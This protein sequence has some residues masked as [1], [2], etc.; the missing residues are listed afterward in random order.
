MKLSQLV[1]IGCLGFLACDS[2]GGDA[3]TEIAVAS[4]TLEV[5]AAEDGEPLPDAAV[6][7]TLDGGEMREPDSQDD[8]G[9]FV[10]DYEETGAFLVTVSAPGFEMLTR[11]YNVV[12]EEGGCHPEGVSDTVELG[13][14]E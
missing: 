14:A 8:G 2:D 9:V 7:F 13:K 3:C 6:S 11:S 5:V 10:L 1:V 4:V 12:L